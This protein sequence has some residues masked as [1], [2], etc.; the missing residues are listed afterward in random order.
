MKTLKNITLTAVLII[1]TANITLANNYRTHRILNS[2]G[3]IIEFFSFIEIPSTEV[4]PGY[5]DF[6]SKTTSN[7]VLD[8]SEIAIYTEEEVEEHLPAFTKKGNNN[9][10]DTYSETLEFIKSIY[11]PEE[12]VDDLPFDTGTFARY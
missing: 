5:E 6:I 3:N 8:I 7:N 10:N 1:M 2:A 12:E 4:I 11:I 9:A